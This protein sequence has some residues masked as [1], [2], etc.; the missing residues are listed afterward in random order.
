MFIL[1]VAS[2]SIYSV[3]PAHDALMSTCYCD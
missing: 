3:I 1:P 2:Q